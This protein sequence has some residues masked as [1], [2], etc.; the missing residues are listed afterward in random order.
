MHQFYP[1]LALNKDEKVVWGERDPLWITLDFLSIITDSEIPSEYEQ[2]RA[3]YSDFDGYSTTTQLIDYNLMMGA[4]GYSEVQDDVEPHDVIFYESNNLIA[5]VVYGHT[6][7]TSNG[8]RMYLM[9]I[10]QLA[11]GYKVYRKTT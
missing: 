6:A 3:S 7:L 5:P 10:D 4:F 11:S 1:W 8:A 2:Y 9:Q